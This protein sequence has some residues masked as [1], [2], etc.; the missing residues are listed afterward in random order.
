MVGALQAAPEAALAFADTLFTFPDHDPPWPPRLA[1]YTR[2][3]AVEGRLERAKRVAEYQLDTA[4]RC[5]PHLVTVAFRGL[6][7][8]EIVDRFGGLHLNP[9]GEFGCDWAWLLQLSMCGPFARVPEVLVEKRRFPASLSRTWRYSLLD[10]LGEWAG[11]VLAVRRAGLPLGEELQLQAHLLG[12][13]AK[14]ALITR[15]WR[16]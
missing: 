2:L 14:A 11:C 4:R 3:D 5:H 16:T 7:R 6:F 10:R 15:G 9:A 12:A 8:A 1:I 13:S